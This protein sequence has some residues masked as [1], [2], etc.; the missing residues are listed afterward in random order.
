MPLFSGLKRL[1]VAVP[2]DSSMPSDRA[3]VLTGLVQIKPGVVGTWL[4]EGG[5]SVQ[6]TP[7]SCPTVLMPS[8]LV[9]VWLVPV[10]K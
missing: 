8:P 4:R 7:S 3:G 6:S 5:Y 1:G 2:S 9:E 10:L